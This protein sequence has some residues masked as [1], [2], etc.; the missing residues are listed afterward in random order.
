[1]AEDRPQFNWLKLARVLLALNGLIWLVIGT[2]SLLRLGGNATSETAVMGAVALLMFGNAAA[3]LLSG[4]LLGRGR[5]L[6][7]FFALAVLLVNVLL[8]FTDQFGLYDL[9]TVLLDFAILGILLF[10]RAGF[11]DPLPRA[12]QAG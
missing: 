2:A 7:Y 8:T 1:M 5:G 12:P 10:K 4:W 11:W 6:A 9:I 3:L